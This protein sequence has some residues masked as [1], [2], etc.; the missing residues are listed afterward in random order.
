MMPSTNVF[1]DLHRHFEYVT[2]VYIQ[3]QMLARQ[4]LC[5]QH[6]ALSKLNCLSRYGH[7]SSG[8]QFIIITL[9]SHAVLEQA[10]VLCSLIGIEMQTVIPPSIYTLCNVYVVNRAS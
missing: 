6:P 3:M 7:L 1:L 10:S 9:V 4:N 2:G 8:I 5:L